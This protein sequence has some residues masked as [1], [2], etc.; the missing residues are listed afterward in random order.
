MSAGEIPSNF[1]DVDSR[2]AV[3]E[4]IQVRLDSMLYQA[5]EQYGEVQR[6][7][8]AKRDDFGMPNQGYLNRLYAATIELVFVA[9]ARAR[10]TE[11]PTPE[12]L[13]TPEELRWVD[14]AKGG[15]RRLAR[16]DRDTGGLDKTF[17]KR[18]R[19]ENSQVYSDMA[20]RRLGVSPLLGTGVLYAAAVANGDIVLDNI[21]LR[22]VR[23]R[24]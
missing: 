6:A 1:G 24:S 19:E 13:E 5:C 12:E 16:H 18:D 21:T 2:R 10:A 17:G 14:Y 9:D 22:D 8:P 11:D 7:T 23:N 15:L 3:E 4:R 20:E